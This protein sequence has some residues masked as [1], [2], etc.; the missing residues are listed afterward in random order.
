MREKR[1][2]GFKS[3]KDVKA[4]HRELCAF[5]PTT[6]PS[7]TLLTYTSKILRMEIVPALGQPGGKHETHKTGPLLISGNG[8]SK[9]IGHINMAQLNGIASQS[10]ASSK[11]RFFLFSPPNTPGTLCTIKFLWIHSAQNI[12]SLRHIYVSQFPDL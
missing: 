10:M 12:Y 1:S 8:L 9:E 11:T 6:R 2:P 7:H 3:E 4:Q 5:V